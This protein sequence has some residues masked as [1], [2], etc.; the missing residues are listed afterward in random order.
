MTTRSFTTVAQAQEVIPGQPLIPIEITVNDRAATREAIIRHVRRSGHKFVE[1]SGWKAKAPKGILEDDWDY[2]MIAL[3]HAGRSYSCGTGAEQMLATQRHQQD[4]NQPHP[5]EDIGYHFGIDCS[6]IV[7]EGRDIRFKGSSVNLYNTGVIGIVL[8]NNLTTPEEGN[9]WVT[10]GRKELKYIGI[11][12]TN[13]N[14]S[15]QIDALLNLTG[16]LKSVFYIEKLGGHR[17]YPGQTKGEGRIC[18]GNI[19]MK[20]VK[21]IR[22]S[23]RLSKP[24]AS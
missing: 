11:D 20:L 14:P 8:L 4:P 17:E 23:T 19:G 6:G 18:P 1:R 9:D 13:Q 21:K 3:H 12:T 7:Y 22:A 2:S 5:F 10:F 16:A 24:P 15:L